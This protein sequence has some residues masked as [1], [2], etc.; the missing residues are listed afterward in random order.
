M[1]TIKVACYTWNVETTWPDQDL[2]A[3]L[4]VSKGPVIKRGLDATL[5]DIY[6]IGLQE[7]K[8]Q[9]QNVI[10]DA[11]FEE[12]WTNAL[13]EVVGPHNY[14]RVAGERLQGL[15]TN[16][17]VKRHHLPH[18][19]D[20]HT[21][22]VRT[23]F[24]G[25]WGNKGATSIRF[26]L[27]GCSVCIVNC[28]LA[29]HDAGYKE[30]IDN[31]NAI[32]DG[33]QFPVTETSNILYHDYVFWLGDVNFRFEGHMTI[34]AIAKH[35]TEGNLSALV[36]ADELRQAQKRG[37]AFSMFTEGKLTFPPT[38]KYLEDTQEYDLMRRPAWTD[39]ILHQVHVDA[40]ENVKLG[41]EQSSYEAV[42]EYM[43]SDHRP[44]RAHYKIKMFANHEDRCVHFHEPGTWLLGEGGPV[45]FTLDSDVITSPS[46]YVALYKVDFTSMHQYITYMYLPQPS[47]G[48]QQTQVYQFTFNDE[49]LQQ[50]GMYRLLYY[51]GKYSSYLGMSDPFPVLPAQS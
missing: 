20:I 26:S 42:Q 4:G 13:R 10:M 37:D 16:I 5:P 2:H 34:E 39:R 32:I 3:L 41:V 14:V 17:F 23:G 46:D 28:H 24:G 22:V 33:I 29:P 9:P 43:Q 21:C 40:Y 30:R 12:P 47:P 18:L 19:R 11:L 8:S 38:Y 51:S 49:L 50:P 44:V 15:V 36:E 6:I 27:Y 48:G 1:E 25:L 45:K 7:V 35:I 31:F